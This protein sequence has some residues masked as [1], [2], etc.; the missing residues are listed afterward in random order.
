MGG[1]EGRVEDMIMDVMICG[2]STSHYTGSQPYT[3]THMH[4]AIESIVQKML[5]NMAS[6]P[7][8]HG[9]NLLA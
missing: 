4:D 8:Q 5:H 9:L 2:G 7:T 6:Y 3:R 1:D